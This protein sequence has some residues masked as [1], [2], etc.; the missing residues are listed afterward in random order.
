MSKIIKF[1][2]D[3]RSKLLEGIN[4]LAD[5]VKVTLGPKGRNVIL[6]KKYG[7]PHV[8]KDGVSVAKEVELTDPVANMGAQLVREVA[9]K[10]CDDAGDGTT[11]AT[12]LAQAIIKEGIKYLAVGANPIDLKRGMDKAVE[13]VISQI[14]EKAIPVGEDFDK[15]ENIATISANNDSEIGQLI[16]QA[17]QKVG[18]EGVIT[19][20]EAKGTETTVET[21]EGMQ[22]DRGYVS[23]YFV[24]DS[25]QMLCTMDNPLILIAHT[26][27]NSLKDYLGV[28]EMAAK[29]DRALLM[30]VDDVDTEALS[31]LVMNRIRGNLR[32]CVV[33]APHFGDRRSE[34]LEDIAVITDAKV[35]NDVISPTPD[36]LGTAE[37]IVVDKERTTIIN[38]NGRPEA[39]ASRAET[40]RNQITADPTSTI[41]SERLAHLSGGV[42]VIH[43]GAASEVEMLEKKD[44]V[45]D[46]LCAT[47]A[48]IEEGVVAGGG[49]TY[50]HA[51]NILFN[52]KGDN[53]DETLG[54]KII[55]K[56]LE[57]PIRQILR[58]A[59]ESPDII[60]AEIDDSDDCYGYNAKTREF[61]DLITTGVV[62]PAKVTRV[63]LENAA[64]VASMFLTTEC[65]IAIKD[66]ET[67][68]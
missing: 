6:G 45:D 68:V 19:I 61:T 28:L 3:A 51:G 21:V 38:G 49:S 7:G 67:N 36:C 35:T 50:L 41:L 2:D 42:A 47:R 31:T 60:I 39:I 43:V 44:R 64:S 33:K 40:I 8:T 57:S 34:V 53:E 20:E 4:T 32:I 13:K 14:K 1:N 26:K 46:A 66:D 18:K 30:I 12:V 11:T 56:A 62:D 52:M 58:N 65:A 23:P 16:A 5:A 24:T 54:I 59:G 17:M 22:F 10:T 27:V 48:A 37:K 25:E 15:I 29:N 9:S 55:H 63:A